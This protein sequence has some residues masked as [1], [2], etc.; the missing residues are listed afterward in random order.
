M[1]GCCQRFSVLQL[2]VWKVV[3]QSNKQALKG[4]T[5]RMDLLKLEYER[6]RHRLEVLKSHL[7]ERDSRDS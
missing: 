4:I 2:R 6:S 5:Q 3:K 1:N 7:E